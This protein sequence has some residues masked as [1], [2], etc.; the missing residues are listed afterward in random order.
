MLGSNEGKAQCWYIAGDSMVKYWSPC[1][2]QHGFICPLIRLYQCDTLPCNSCYRT[3]DLFMKG[4]SI[5]SSLVFLFYFAHTLSSLLSPPDYA[6]GRCLSLFQPGLERWSLVA[7]LCPSRGTFCLLCQTLS[8]I[9]HVFSGKPPK[10]LIGRNSF[11]FWYLSPKNK[12]KRFWCLVWSLLFFP[13]F[14]K[15]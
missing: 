12:K 6:I 3:I 10:K 14:L 9:K 2:H 15:K 13:C 1:G 5:S 8:I 4:C 7:I 11:R